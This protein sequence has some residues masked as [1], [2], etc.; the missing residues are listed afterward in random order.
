MADRIPIVAA[1][2]IA[3]AH[4]YEQVIIYARRIGPNG[5]EWVTT[6][7]INPTHCTA[8][9]RIGDALRDQVVKP[10]ERAREREAL[11]MGAL[12]RICASADALDDLSIPAIA[13]ARSLLLQLEA[14]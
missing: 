10:L 11:A 2:K 7:G 13:E 14:A 8:A 12:K 3:K 6:Y 4:G 9:A 1:E 5:L